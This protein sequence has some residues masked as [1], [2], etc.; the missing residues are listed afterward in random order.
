[1]NKS[2]IVKKAILSEKAYEL[3]KKGVYTFLVDS[4]ARKEAI[5]DFVQKQF[6]VKVKMVNTAKF[7]P[8]TKRIAKTRKT[9]K[10]GGGKK[11]IVTLKAGEKIQMLAPKTESKKQKDKSKGNNEKEK[12]DGGDK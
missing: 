11:A 8:K 3:M 5:T 2:D 9:I 7:A 10:T 1:M 4:R 6:A 12:I